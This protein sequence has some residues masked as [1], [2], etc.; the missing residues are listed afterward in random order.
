MTATVKFKVFR[1]ELT[2]WD[3]LFEQAADFAMLIG[4]DRVINISHSWGGPV[5]LVT[6]WYWADE[7]S[8]RVDIEDERLTV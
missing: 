5:G 6:V 1:S 3:S 7:P 4:K 8:N 2:S